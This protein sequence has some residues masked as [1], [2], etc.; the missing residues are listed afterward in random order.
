MCMVDR[1]GNSI[2]IWLT[3]RFYTNNYAIM[4]ETEISGKRGSR[5]IENNLAKNAR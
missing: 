5:K 3:H 4:A 1:Y 2:F